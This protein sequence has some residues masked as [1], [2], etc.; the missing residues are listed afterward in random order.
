M[1]EEYDY[2]KE[3]KKDWITILRI[4]IIAFTIGVFIVY[5]IIKIL[6]KFF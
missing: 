6:A 1:G 3:R 4:G 5:A 2:K